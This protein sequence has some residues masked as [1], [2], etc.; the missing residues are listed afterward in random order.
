MAPDKAYQRK[1]TQTGTMPRVDVEPILRR[2]PP[3]AESEELPELRDKDI[4]STTG[5]MPTIFIAPDDK[6]QD[7]DT[8]TGNK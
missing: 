3:Q 2:E 4:G 7:E 6:T 5:E 8:P 1:S